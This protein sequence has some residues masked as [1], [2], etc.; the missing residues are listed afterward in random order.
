[1]QG[2]DSSTIFRPV[3]MELN[4]KP[5]FMNARRRMFPVETVVTVTRLERR[6]KDAV[7]YR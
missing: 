1:M 5:R 7:K 3:T 4:A 6:V 2:P